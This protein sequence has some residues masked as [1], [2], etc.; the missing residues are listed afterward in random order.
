M[1][2]TLSAESTT[3]RLV[4]VCGQMGVMTKASQ[5]LA[6]DRPAR[7][8]AVGR[9]AD[10]RAQDQ[11]V[12]AEA[13]YGFA[14]HGQVEVDHVKRRP[15]LNDDLV[16]PQEGPVLARGFDQALEHQV[17]G[18]PILAAHDAAENKPAVRRG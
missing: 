4:S 3:G 14:V 11:A 10:R 15:G 7:R 8:Q 12:A 16:E 1:V 17:L 2:Y 18:D 5:L 6:Q 9:R 13:G